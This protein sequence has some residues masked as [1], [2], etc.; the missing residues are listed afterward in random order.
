[1]A[2]VDEVK[3][4]FIETRMLH[5]YVL[6]IKH[7]FQDVRVSGSNARKTTTPSMASLPCGSGLFDSIDSHRFQYPWWFSNRYVQNPGNFGQMVP[8]KSRSLHTPVRLFKMFQMEN[9]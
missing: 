3:P 4:L 5:R 6:I 2:T 9:Y 1:M 7:I 8:W